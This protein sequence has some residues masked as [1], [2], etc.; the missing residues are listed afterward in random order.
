M[1]WSDSTGGGGLSA[2]AIGYAQPSGDDR[3]FVFDTGNGSVI[4]TTFTYNRHTDTWKWLMEIEKGVERTQ[5]A[6]V[7]LTRQ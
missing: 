1:L 4:H 7:V 5:F 3:P 2:Q 6:R